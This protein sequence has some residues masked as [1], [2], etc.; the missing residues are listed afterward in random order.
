L[1]AQSLAELL[2]RVVRHSGNHFALRS[3]R[4]SIR[5]PKIIEIGIP[6]ALCPPRVI[7]RDEEVL[8]DFTLPEPIQPHA[9]ARANPTELDEPN[10][11]PSAY[12][13][14]QHPRASGA[15]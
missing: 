7:P 9:A 12:L 5:I 15:G 3:N 10:F 8:F 14:K 6:A 13:P 1:F 11:Q 2:A 4:D